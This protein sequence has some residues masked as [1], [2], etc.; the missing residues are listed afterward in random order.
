MAVRAPTDGFLTF[1]LAAHG[2][3]ESAQ[4]KI[5]ELFIALE[6]ETVLEPVTVTVVIESSVVEWAWPDLQR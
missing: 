3:D 1:G 6:A 5:K 2:D 4:A